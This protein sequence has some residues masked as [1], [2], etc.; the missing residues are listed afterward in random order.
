MQENYYPKAI[1]LSH[2]YLSKGKEKKL[3]IDKI[4]L[5]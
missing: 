2:A 4:E 5:D 3:A 1:N